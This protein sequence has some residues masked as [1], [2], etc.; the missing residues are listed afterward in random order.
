MED[1][2]LGVWRTLIC[3]CFLQPSSCTSPN[4]RCRRWHYLQYPRD[5]SQKSPST[6]L[7]PYDFAVWVATTLFGQARAE[8]ELDE[9]VLVFTDG[10][11]GIPDHV[12]WKEFKKRGAQ[13][14][15]GIIEEGSLEDLQ[16]YATHIETL[17]DF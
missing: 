4:H 7:A 13:L 9:G 14:H 1:R 11:T 16:P 10:F 2:A 17:P 15:V 12:S 8:A 5:V 3:S 6:S